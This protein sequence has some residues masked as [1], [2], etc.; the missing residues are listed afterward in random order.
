ME[1][2]KDSKEELELVE[3][4]EWVDNVPLTRTKKNINRD[5]C[6]GGKICIKKFY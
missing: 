5:F 6:D 1:N 4:Y 3:V 2:N